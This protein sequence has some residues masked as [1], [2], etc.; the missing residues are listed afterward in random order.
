MLAETRLAARTVC[1]IIRGLQ[2]VRE[3]CMRIV[4][5]TVLYTILA[6]IAAASIAAQRPES[7]KSPRVYIFDG[8]KITGLDPK[9]FGFSR[10]EIK[11]PDFV[12]SSYLVVHPKGTL[13][14]DA[15]AIPDADLKAD[16]TPVTEGVVD[17]H[18]QLKPQMAAAGYKPAD[19]TYFALSHYHSDHTAN[20]N[21]FAGATWIV[22]KAE[23]DAMLAPDPHGH[24]PARTLQRA[25]EREDEDPRQRGLRRLRRRDGRHQGCARAHAWAPGALRQACEDGPGAPRRRPLP[26]P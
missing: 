14:F 1:G 15:G 11:E 6:L 21:D 7:P 23:R 22:Q 17:R 3:L 13:M 16:G 5:R 25:Q 9:L 8:G 20:A 19:V 10:E 4:S 2:D 18:R 12:N 26:L 24:H